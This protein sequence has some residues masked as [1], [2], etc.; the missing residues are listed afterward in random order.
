MNSRRRIPYVIEHS[1]FDRGK[2]NKHAEWAAFAVNSS[3]PGRRA[4]DA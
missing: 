2:C 4:F 3:A 1:L